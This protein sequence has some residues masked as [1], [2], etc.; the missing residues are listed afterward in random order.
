VI[1]PPQFGLFV[2][3]GRN[4]YCNYRNEYFGPQCFALIQCFPDLCF[5]SIC[6][7]SIVNVSALPQIGQQP[8][9]MAIAHVIDSVAYSLW[10]R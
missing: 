2:S 9:D 1:G 7:R 3:S 4:R 8:I 10:L 6:P 5:I